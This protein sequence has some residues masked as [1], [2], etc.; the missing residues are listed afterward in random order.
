M[1][2]AHFTVAERLL[3]RE[4]HALIARFD[5]RMRGLAD[6]WPRSASDGPNLEGRTEPTLE[7]AGLFSG[8]EKRIL[9]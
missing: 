3:S 9:R 2:P 8:V 6:V 4:M 5:Q 1:R 7:V